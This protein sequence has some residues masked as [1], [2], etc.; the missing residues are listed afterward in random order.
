MPDWIKDIMAEWPQ[1][2]AAPRSFA[3]ITII[4]IVVV[5]SVAWLVISWFYSAVLAGKDAQIAV[6]RDRI[7]AYEQKLQGATPDQVA[8]RINELRAELADT[9][10]QLN[11]LQHPPRN[12]DGLYQLGE[13]VATVDGASIDRGNS[14]VVFQ[15]VRSAGKLD[16]SKEV[17]FRD[18]VL[19]CVGLPLA[20]PTN[21]KSG[22]TSTVSG[23]AQCKI[24]PRRQ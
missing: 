19:Q 16:P 1:I 17:E 15:F 12:P 11:D 2:R 20:A 14:L 18:F 13:Q 24:I 23:G 21:A 3:I 22:F 10:K 5:A 7:S 8:T 9:K 4:S 6:L